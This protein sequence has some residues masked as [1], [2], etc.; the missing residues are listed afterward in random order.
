MVPSSKLIMPFILINLIEIYLVS[1]IFAEMDITLKLCIVMETSIYSLLLLFLGKN[2]SWNK[3]LGI[4]VG[5]QSSSI[6][7]YVEPLTGEVFTARFAD[8]HFNENVFPPLGGGKP[9]PE[10][11]RKITWNESSLSHFDPPTKQSE[12]EVQKIIHLQDLANRLP[13][14]FIDSTKVTKSQLKRGRPLG[15]KDTIPRKK[16]C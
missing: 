9:I 15:S 2:K 12:L 5:F 1:R 13:D 8:C 4:Y 7:T 3:W 6:I 16:K 11:W 10:E 14:A